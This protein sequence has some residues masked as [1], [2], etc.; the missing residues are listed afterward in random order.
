MN[1]QGQQ[2]KKQEPQKQPET[3]EQLAVTVS[4]YG[5]RIKALEEGMRM[6]MERVMHIEN[7]PH[8]GAM[9]AKAKNEYRL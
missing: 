6:L 3:Q 8:I 7:L 5:Q 1:D 4:K 9:P 2:Q